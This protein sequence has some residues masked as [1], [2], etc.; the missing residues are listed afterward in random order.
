[1]TGLVLSSRMISVVLNARPMRLPERPP[2]P[3]QPADAE[4]MRG[5]QR[6]LID[7][8]NTH[9]DAFTSEEGIG[10]AMAYLSGRY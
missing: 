2:R 6:L 8:V 3:E 1:M 10:C 4:A 9:P 7:L 5:R